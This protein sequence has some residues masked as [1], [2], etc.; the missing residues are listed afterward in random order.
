[1]NAM[2]TLPWQYSNERTAVFI[3]GAN[4]FA[5]SKNLN[6]EVDYRSLL[7]YLQHTSQLV[8]AYYYAVIVDTENYSP[9]KPLTDF[10]SYNGFIMVSKTVRE[11]QDGQS[12]RSR[13]NMHVD[14]TVDM[15]EMAS[16]IE[17]MI[18]FSGDSELR[19]PVEYVQRQGVRVTVVSS[20]STSIPMVS[21]E[22]RRQADLFVD[23]VDISEN[24]TRAQANRSPVRNTRGDAYASNDVITTLPGSY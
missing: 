8:R 6:F 4:L 18:L 16:K 10:L 21:D 14:M 23:L 11:S 9:L 2:S 12:N 15:M 24:F 3:D 13:N 17:H 19:R 7:S 5:A 22:L 1:M 20:T